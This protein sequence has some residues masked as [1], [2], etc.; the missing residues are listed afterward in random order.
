MSRDEKV[1]NNLS[2]SSNSTAYNL[3][4]SGKYWAASSHIS[5]RQFRCYC[6][7]ESSPIKQK[8]LLLFLIHR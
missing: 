8:M 3:Y 7:S 1:E 2:Q 4:G 6:L 5:L